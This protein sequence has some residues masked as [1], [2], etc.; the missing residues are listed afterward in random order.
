[1]MDD[2]GNIYK[3]KTQE[4]LMQVMQDNF[5]TTLSDEEV[6]L[7]EKTKAEERFYTLTE[8]R[9]MRRE[10]QRQER[11]EARKIYRNSRR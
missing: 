10:R 2:S 11:R 1:M 5:V 9:A 8:N 3:L 6:K 7:M 4:E